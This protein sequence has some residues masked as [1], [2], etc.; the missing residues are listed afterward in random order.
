MEAGG[1][2]ADMSWTV[3]DLP[4]HGED[5]EMMA[6]L[7]SA[8]PINGEEEGQQELPWFDQSSNPCYY[9]CNASSTAYSNSNASSLAAPSEYEGYCLSDSN[10]TLGVSSNIAPHDLSMVQVQGATDFLNV[11]PN[12]SLDSYGNGE[13][14]REDLD[15]VSGT[16]KR[17]H[18]AE[19]EFDGQ[20][21]G[22][23]CAKKA[24]PKR[25]KKAKQSGQ[26]DASVTIP[27]GSCSTSDN[28]SSSS[29]EAADAGATSK[30]K[31]RAGR[32]AATDPQS[33]Y[34][35]KR[36]ERINERLKTLQNLVPN[37]TKVDISTM[38][39]EAVHYVKFLQIQIKLLS[40][41]EMWMYAPIAY[42]GM[43]IG[44]DLNID[45]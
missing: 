3:F 8:F 43:N 36:R 30:G 13:P 37:G 16:N 29:Q 22:S 17:K 41:D 45:R 9:N 14:S 4:S 2:I 40:S 5:S 44:L 15:S 35:R 28:D 1:L 33:L 20:T 18:S 31:S 23:K 42:N 7:L 12:H 24:E 38:L 6:Q 27:N 34:A 11:I 10:E 32:G 39:E 19:E 26:K 21:R 25:M